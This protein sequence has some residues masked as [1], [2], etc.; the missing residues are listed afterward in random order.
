[1]WEI[2]NKNKGDFKPD[3]EQTGGAD[4]V[5]HGKHPNSAH[6]LTSVAVAPKSCYVAVSV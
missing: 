3:T 2:K 6:V 4:T 1:M 5:V